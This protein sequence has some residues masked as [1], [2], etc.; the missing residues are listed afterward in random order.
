[1]D[2][3]TAKRLAKKILVKANENYGYEIALYKYNGKYKIHKNRI[4]DKNIGIAKYNPPP[5]GQIIKRLICRDDDYP[6]IDSYIEKFADTLI[7]A[8]EMAF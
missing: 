8:E 6:I 7:M 4:K 5:K 1:M 2:K 3:T